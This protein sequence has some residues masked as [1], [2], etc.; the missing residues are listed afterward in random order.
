M[1]GAH[2]ANRLHGMVYS[3]FFFRRRCTRLLLYFNT[4]KPLFFCRIPVVLENRRSSQGGRGCAP[5][6]PSPWI[7]PVLCILVAIRRYLHVFLSLYRANREISVISVYKL[8][9]T[10]PRL[11]CYNVAWVRENWRVGKSVFQSRTG[12]LTAYSYRLQHISEEYQR[13]NMNYRDI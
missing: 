9:V 8:L 3:G 5:P 4:N 10:D 2:R 13:I 1:R 11:V 7:H 6:A 12:L